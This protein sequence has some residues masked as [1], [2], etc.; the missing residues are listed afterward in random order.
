MV[1]QALASFDPTRNNF[2][3]LP[4]VK[5]EAKVETPAPAENAATQDKE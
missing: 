3:N 1:S 4:E 5:P 2:E